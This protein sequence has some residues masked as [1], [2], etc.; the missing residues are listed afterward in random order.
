MSF[1]VKP[2]REPAMLSELACRQEWRLL[3]PG[4]LWLSGGADDSGESAKAL[5]EVARLLAAIVSGPDGL[6]L[7]GA[8][9]VEVF[10]DAGVDDQ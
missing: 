6:H 1:E 2:A 9:A 3:A 4:S 8:P 10:T 7:L 5:L